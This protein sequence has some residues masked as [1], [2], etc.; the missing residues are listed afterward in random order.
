[1]KRLVLAVACMAVLITGCG[2]APVGTVVS[3]KVGVT[4]YSTFDR[5]AAPEIAGPTLTGPTVSLADYRGKV[6]VLNNWA[7]W[8]L[9]CNDEAPTLVAAARKYASKDVAF[10]GL[11]VSDQDASAREFTATYGVPYPSIIDAS[12]RQ[13][14]RLPGVPPEALPTTL[15]IDRDGNIAVRI[16]GAVKEPVFSQLIDQL[17]A[18]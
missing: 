16:I 11:D 4:E 10:V 7:S 17:L 18:E 1:V 12:G 6:V 2:R 13:L 3:E 15:I 14:A 8:C 9:P 5:I